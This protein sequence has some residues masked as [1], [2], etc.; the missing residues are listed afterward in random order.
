[1]LVFLIADGHGFV[2][3]SGL[4]TDWWWL[5]GNNVGLWVYVMEKVTDDVPRT[6][7]CWDLFQLACPVSYQGAAM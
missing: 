2:Y 5:W 1:M 4:P 7:L 6:V 3:F